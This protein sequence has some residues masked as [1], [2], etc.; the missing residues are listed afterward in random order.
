MA[1]SS[2]SDLSNDTNLVSATATSTSTDTSQ[3]DSCNVE[4]PLINTIWD[5]DKVTKCGDKGTDSAM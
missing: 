3:N 2:I 5:D 1:T 4:L